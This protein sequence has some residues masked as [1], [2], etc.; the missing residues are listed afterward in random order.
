V[1]FSKAS[2]ASK[3]SACRGRHGAADFF[4]DDL[5]DFVVVDRA[6]AAAAPKLRR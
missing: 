5:A 6:R 2:K 4:A 1:Y 3:V